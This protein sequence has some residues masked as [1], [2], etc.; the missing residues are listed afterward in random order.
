[1]AFGEQ[2]PPLERRDEVQVSMYESSLARSLQCRVM[3]QRPGG[4][5][6]AEGSEDGEAEWCVR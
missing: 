3:T 1:M 5:S 4:A 6:E 2:P